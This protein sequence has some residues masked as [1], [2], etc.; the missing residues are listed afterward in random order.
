MAAFGMT[1]A[2]GVS[3]LLEA[4]GVDVAL[5]SHAEVPH[6]RQIVIHP[7]ERRLEVDRVVALPELSGPRIVG[8]PHDEHGF[9]PVDEHGRVD[10]AP[11]VFA[12]GDIAAY[13]IKHGGFSAQQA[14]AVAQAIA[15]LAGEQ[16]DPKPVQVLLR[17]MI[18][19][20]A[21][22][23]FISARISGG[24]AFDSVFTQEPNLNPASKI[25]ARYLDAYLE[26]RDLGTGAGTG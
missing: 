19:T 14:D 16:L 10:G 11:G 12:A 21:E 22:P 25:A 23:Y 5:A 26:T 9:V 3:R 20:G 4:G 18:L 13:A 1:V 8:V 2:Q 24:H 6:S 15:V 7:G 17:G